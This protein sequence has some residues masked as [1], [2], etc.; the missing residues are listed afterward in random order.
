MAN[1]LSNFLHFGRICFVP[2]L[3]LHN[4]LSLTDTAG[5]VTGVAGIVGKGSASSVKRSAPSAAEP[6]APEAATAAIKSS[7]AAA[8]I[9]STASAVESITRVRLAAAAAEPFA[10]AAVTTAIGRGRG[11]PLTRVA[12]V[13]LRIHGMVA[14]VVYAAPAAVAVML[15]PATAGIL[16]DVAVH[17]RVVIVANSGSAHIVAIRSAH[18][19]AGD[20]GGLSCIDIA[21]CAARTGGGDAGIWIVGRSARAAGVIAGINILDRSTLAG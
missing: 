12:G 10:I 2:N 17:V 4:R 18:I 7:S 3:R 20:I 1:D 16:V 8:A 11:A 19:G 14:L 9:E 6:T 15:L 13:L 21:D 5:A